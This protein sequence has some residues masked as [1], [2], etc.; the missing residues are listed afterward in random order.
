[1]IADLVAC[2]LRES[3]ILPFRDKDPQKAMR[4]IKNVPLEAP[5]SSTNAFPPLLHSFRGWS[6]FKQ[7]LS[8]VH[9]SGCRCFDS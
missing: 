5:T 8:Y 9:I 6:F 3:R 1:M 7:I 2:S 4:I